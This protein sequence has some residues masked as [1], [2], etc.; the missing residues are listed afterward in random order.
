MCCTSAVD[1]Q[2]GYVPNV[3]CVLNMYVLYV[4][5]RSTCG[6]FRY[7]GSWAG[8]DDD[9]YSVMLMDRG[10]GCW[11]GPERSVKVRFVSASLDV[12]SCSSSFIT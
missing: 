3:S 2:L 12:K 8:R 11:N 7:W 9:R 1:T 6:M 10:Q 5:S 4:C